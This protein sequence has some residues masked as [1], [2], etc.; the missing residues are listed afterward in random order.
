MRC[1]VDSILNTP[2]R[3][4][5]ARICTAVEL[6]WKF[7]SSGKILGIL[8]CALEVLMREEAT[9]HSEAALLGKDNQRRRYTSCD[10][11]IFDDFLLFIIKFIFEGG[12]L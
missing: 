7:C 1:S 12:E 11:C 3:N 4:R 8:L 9:S 10:V 6:Q 5:H 2:I